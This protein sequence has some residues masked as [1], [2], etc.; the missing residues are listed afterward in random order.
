MTVCK[1]QKGMTTVRATAILSACL[2]FRAFAQSPAGPAFEVASIK[3]APPQAPGRVS[4]RM[5]IDPA[6]LTFTNVSL[7]EVIGQAFRVQH[8][9]ISGPEWLEQER[10][11]IFAKI[12]DGVALDQIP[13]MLQSL[14]A[15]RFQMKLHTDQKELPV[16]ALAAAKNGPKLK[17]ADSSTGFTSGSDGRSRHVTANISMPRFAEYLADRVGRPVLDQTGLDGNYVVQLEWT[18]DQSEEPSAPSR[19]ADAAI[20]TA[21]PSL[22][23]ALQQ[24]LGLKLTATKGPVQ[25]LVIDSISK[26]AKPN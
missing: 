13:R 18:P 2:A 6:R 10:F 3:P 23:Q 26:A 20:D 4:T 1:R 22:F 15:E 17:K 5:S 25:V 19:P 16:Y 7:S 24:E 12:P 21:R 11:D 8:Q 14:L 9:Q